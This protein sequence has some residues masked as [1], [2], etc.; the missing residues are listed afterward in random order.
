MSIHEA[1]LV[2]GQDDD[3]SLLEAFFHCEQTPIFVAEGSHDPRQ[4]PQVR[5]QLWINNAERCHLKN[6]SIGKI[7]EITPWGVTMEA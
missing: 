3:G 7:I 1:S 4:P 5:P 2:R 6:E